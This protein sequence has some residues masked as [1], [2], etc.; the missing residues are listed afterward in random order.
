[1]IR[2]II[3]NGKKIQYEFLYKNVKNINIR[4][5]PDGKINVSASRHVPQAAVEDFM[6]SK[7]EFILKAL[8]RFE[9]IPKKSK[10]QQFGENEI[11][12]V[13]SSVC[14]RVYPYFKEKGIE[15]PVIKFRK[16][17][18]QWG[19]C[20]PKKGVLTFNTNLMYASYECIEYVVLHEFTHF[21]E[22]NHS[23]KFYKEL[24]KTCPDWKER[25]EKLKEI[26]LR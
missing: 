25:R 9:K 12:D 24:E 6:I 13:I 1:M 7:A 20:Y 15:Y 23:G 22:A 17:V 4:I 21:L 16:M 2:E 10:I 19:N 26:S 11:I 3:L 14:K 18:S 8:E 5:K